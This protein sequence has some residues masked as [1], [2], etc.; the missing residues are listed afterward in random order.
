[1]C[2]IWSP[3]LCALRFD[4]YVRVILVLGGP[5]KQ[6]GSMCGYVRGYVRSYV[7]GDWVSGW[8]GGWVRT[9]D[10]RHAY[11]AKRGDGMG[12]WSGMLGL[13]GV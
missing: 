6:N 4:G 2:A 9:Y 10:W 3:R 12:G 5:E 1:M 13:L 8:V 7:R 11:W